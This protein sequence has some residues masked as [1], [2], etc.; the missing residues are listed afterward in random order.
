M[1][2]AELPDLS[3]RIM[4]VLAIDALAP[5]VEFERRWY[6]WGAV[7]AQALGVYERLARR[8]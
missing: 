2:R 5:A 3:R 8:A 1:E 7:A 6:E 4:Q